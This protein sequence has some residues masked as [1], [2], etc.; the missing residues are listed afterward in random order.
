MLTFR[1]DESTFAACDLAGLRRVPGAGLRVDFDEFAPDAAALGL[2]HL[3]NGGC[4]GEGAGLEDA[5][6]GG[7]PMAAN[8]AQ[9]VEDGYRMDAGDAPAAG[10]F[11]RPADAQLTCEAWVRD[12]GNAAASPGYLLWYAGP[13]TSRLELWARRD[14][15]SSLLRVVLRISGTAVAVASWSGQDVDAL[16]AGAA[17]W[18]VAVVLD[19]P[20]RLAVY[21]NGTLR[22]EAASGVVSLPAGNWT[23]QLSLPATP[24][25]A[26]VDEVR[27]SSSVRYAAAFAPKRLLAGGTCASPTFDAARL[28]AQWADV[29]SDAD[30]PAGTSLAWDVRAA[31]ETDPAGDPQAPWQPWTGDPAALPVGRYFQWRASPAAGADRLTTPTLA[32]VDALASEVGYNLYR[33]AGDAPEAIDYAAGPWAR[34][35]PGVLALDTPAL[36]APAVHWFAVRP[37]DAAGRETPLAQDELRLELDAAGAVVPDRPAPVLD[38]VA[39]ALPGGAVRLAWRYRAGTAAPG[40]FRIFGDGGTGVIDYETPLAVVDASPDREAYAW[41]TSALAPGAPHL[42][43]V[44]AATDGNVW[45]AGPAA[46][47]SV[48]PD[49]TPPA[50]VENLLAE[51]LT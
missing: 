21:V 19:A 17:P 30:L 43:A 29:M 9:P 45:D 11:T 24:A 15:A 18:H 33:A 49:A 40:E 35:G 2:W 47:C 8:G 13:A 22:A 34:V 6:G 16:L 50:A 31:D 4:T 27:L 3:H 36:N 25:L 23:L 32:A 28:S 14:G 20:S 42:L 44:R 37:V 26:V 5:S 46:A 12:W 41:E 7:H 38:P 51:T 48:T 10:P 1:I 39:A